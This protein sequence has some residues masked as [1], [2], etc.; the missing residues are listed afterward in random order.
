MRRALARGF[1][2]GALA[3]LGCSE[4]TA[5]AAPN[6]DAAALTHP[7]LDGVTWGLEWDRRDAVVN[8]VD[9][10]VT[11]DLGFTFAVD[12]GWLVNYSVTLVPCPDTVASGAWERLLG[13]G[14]AHADHPDFDDPSELTPKHPE[15]LARPGS[16]ALGAIAFDPVQYCQ[17]HWLVAQADAGAQ[18]TD[19]TDLSDVSLAVSADWVGPETAGRLDITTGWTHGVLLDLAMPSEPAAGHATVTLV[20]SLD[21]LFDGV[22]PTTHT[23]LEIAWTLLSNLVEHATV[24]LALDPKR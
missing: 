17:V 3:L 2:F 12:A 24:R 11:N 21:G 23:D 1:A 10:S 22:D 19:G 5:P 7:V 13:I 9:W 15:S 4:P 16:T 18:A 14:L 8:E 20:R 6:Q